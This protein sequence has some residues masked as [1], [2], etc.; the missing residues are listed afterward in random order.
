MKS[1]SEIRWVN[2][3][4]TQDQAIKEQAKDFWRK[5]KVIRREEVLARRAEQLV[6]LAYNAKEE[7]I[8]IST[9]LKSKVKLLNDNYLY[10]YRCLVDPNHRVLGLDV[11]LTLES[12]KELEAAAKN[13]PD[14]P[15]GV[16][17]VVE[18]EKLHGDKI[19]RAAV[20]R[21]Y[22]MYF[23]GYDSK[24][25]PVRVYYFEGARI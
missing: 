10:Q 24:D 5:H 9:A 15:I 14:K 4:G 23:V 17:V 22:K 20:W 19:H 16:F 7:V 8:A 2:V 12:L 13:D 25:Q 11:H 1:Q 3:W 6:Y 21:A 18:N